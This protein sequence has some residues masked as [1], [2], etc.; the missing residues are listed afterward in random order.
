MTIKNLEILGEKGFRTLFLAERNISETEY[1]HFKEEFKKASLTYERSKELMEETYE[2]LEKDLILLGATAIEDCL[3]D[4]LKVTLKTFRQ[5]GIKLWMLTGDNALTAVSIAH[6]CGLISKRFISSMIT[7]IN[8][9]DSQLEEINRKL[10]VNKVKKEVDNESM[11]HCLVITGDVLSLILNDDTF[12]ELREDITRQ[13]LIK[14]GNKISETNQ[15]TNSNLP[16]IK[17]VE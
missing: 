16:L 14:K 2:L 9:I 3:Q 5:S 8:D 7:D 10:D 15:I 17:K 6:S 1:Y 11:K 4:D 13:K 12:I